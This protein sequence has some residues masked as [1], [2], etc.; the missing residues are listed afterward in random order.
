MHEVPTRMTTI[1]ISPPGLET[2]WVERT[3]SFLRDQGMRVVCLGSLSIIGFLLMSDRI[4]GVLV[5]EDSLPAEWETIRARMARFALSSKIIVVPREEQRSSR[6][7]A[8]L[9]AP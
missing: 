8:A 6:D 3:A 7:L 5:H 9:V 1:I 2:R 4:A